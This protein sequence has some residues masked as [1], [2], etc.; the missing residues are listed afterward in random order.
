MVIQNGICPV[1][2]LMNVLI[3]D[4]PRQVNPAHRL[5][6][7][8]PLET[9]YLST[10]EYKHQ[11]QSETVVAEDNPNSLI[12]R[13]GENR[14]KVAFALLFKQFGPKLKSLMLR[15]G[16]NTSTAEELVQETMLSVWRKSHTFDSSKASAS[17][18]MF[19]IARNLRIDRFRSES[20]PEFDPSDPSL[21]PEPELQADEQL[22]LKNRQ[23]YVRKCLDELPNDQR[24]V[25]KMSFMQGL[26]HQEIS[27]K[28]DIPLGTVKSRLRLSFGKLRTTM[29]KSDG[30]TPP[31]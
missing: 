7:H 16:T 13:I 15:L 19:T 31:K 12:Q 1:L 29:E 27:D 24:E 11:K 20:R 9:R 22:E 21:I 30:F 10:L 3:S 23:N 4:R 2:I 5:P 18:W 28:L 14:D 17:T 6:L 8:V 25:V 26:S